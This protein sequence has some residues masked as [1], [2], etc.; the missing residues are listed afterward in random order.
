MRRPF[1]PARKAKLPP[2][3]KAVVA[4]HLFLDLIHGKIEPKAMGL[5]LREQVGLQWTW[6]SCMQYLSGKEALAVFSALP[7]E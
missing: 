1:A 6:L 5:R 2:A 3:V 7:A 4:G